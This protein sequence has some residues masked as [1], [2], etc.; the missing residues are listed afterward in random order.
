MTEETGAM[1]LLIVM[2][3]CALIAMVSIATLPRN[4]DTVV[5]G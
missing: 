3:T 2:F 1:P 5:R 4:L